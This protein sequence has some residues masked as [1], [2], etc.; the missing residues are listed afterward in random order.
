MSSLYAKLALTLFLL[1]MVVGVVQ[2]QTVRRA[3]ELYQQEVA[4][5]LNRDLARS[6]VGEQSLMLGENINSEALEHLFHQLMVINPSI[7]LYLLDNNGNILAFSA[8]QGK[9][10]LQHVPLEPLKSF[11]HGN[12]RFPLLGPDPRNVGQQKAFSAAEIMH[13]G[14][15]VGYLYIIL[16]SELYAGAAQ[17]LKGSFIMKAASGWLLGA[18]VIAALVGLL[19]FAWLTRRLSRLSR[20][21]QEYAR[22]HVESRELSAPRPDTGDEVDRLAQQFE[23]MAE[24][25]DIQM[26][27]LQQQDAARREMVANISH[28]LRTPLTTLQGYLETLQLK[29]DRLSDQERQHYIEITLSHGKQLSRLVTE[30][31]ELAKLDACDNILLAEPFSLAELVQDVTH[32]LQLPAEQ[33]A[34]K[35]RADISPGVPLVYGDIGLMQ[36]V[37]EN[38]IE[39]ALRHTPSGGTVSVGV[40]AGNNAVAVKVHDS[41]KGIA[42]QD[43]PHIFDRFYRADKSRSQG[44]RGAGLGLAIVRRILELHG[45]TISVDSRLEEG[46]TFSFQLAVQSALGESASAV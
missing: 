14:K 46:T 29:G 32:K 9:V 23:R 11:I 40:V 22:R 4:Q 31:F 15:Q 17:Q 3:S 25:I 42:E 1:L 36:R 35:L 10:K 19:V 21:M 7:E 39:N 27:K 30:L 18:M 12:A 20:R 41:G 5:R 43:I 24:L 33:R 13:E 37:L 26:E 16:G 45:S 44:S 28:D 2:L 8:P 34:I 38:L 6:I